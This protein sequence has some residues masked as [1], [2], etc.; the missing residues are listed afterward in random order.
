[1]VPA[2]WSISPRTEAEVL[3][4]KQHVKATWRDS[5]ERFYAARN[6]ERFQKQQSHRSALY[7][8]KLLQIFKNTVTYKTEKSPKQKTSASSKLFTTTVN[9]LRISESRNITIYTY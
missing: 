7:L 1:M 6:G 9:L 8:F 2:H 3:L 4:N 5:E